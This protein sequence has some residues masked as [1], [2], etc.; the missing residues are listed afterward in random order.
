MNL[1]KVLIKHILQNE[2]SIE[3]IYDCIANLDN[4]N[5]SLGIEW[6]F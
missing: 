4:G 1:G 5:V 3:S 6:F 2:N